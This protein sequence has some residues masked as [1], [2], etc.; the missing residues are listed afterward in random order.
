MHDAPALSS[1]LLVSADT[2]AGAPGDN[3]APAAPSILSS[4]P[5]MIAIFAVFY[6]LLIRPQQKE[7]KLQQEL[8]AGLRKGDE[9]VTSSGIF[10]TVWEVQD[11][12]V[13]NGTT[14]NGTDFGGVDLTHVDLSK[15]HLIGV[16]LSNKQKIHK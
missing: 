7:A 4:L 1:T 6:F 8:L 12:A 11:G 15:A 13:L 2:P 3:T 9:V 5:M 10:G 14:F 16:D